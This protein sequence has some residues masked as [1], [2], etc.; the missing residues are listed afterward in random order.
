[1]K[2][3][4]PLGPPN[5]HGPAQIIDL[6][7]FKNEPSSPVPSLSSS[8]RGF[9]GHFCGNLRLAA[10]DRGPGRRRPRRRRWMITRSWR[11][12]ARGRTVRCTRR[13][14]R[15]RGSSLRSRSRASRWTQRA[16]TALLSERFPSS[17]ISPNP[18]TSSS[19]S[20]S[21]FPLPLIIASILC[22]ALCFFFWFC[23]CV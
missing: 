17:S 3:T 18:F 9:S 20:L 11:R 19:I 13:R 23:D 4:R 6:R 22:F 1:M 10:P 5:N 8:R 16:S 14:T 7:S 12:S 2:A 15:R 21:S